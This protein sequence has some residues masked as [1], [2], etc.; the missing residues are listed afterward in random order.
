MDVADAEWWIS[1]AISE[2]E[3]LTQRNSIATDRGCRRVAWF[4]LV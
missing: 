4:W 3:K 1:S 2:A